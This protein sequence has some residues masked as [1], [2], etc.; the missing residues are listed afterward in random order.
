MTLL[1]ESQRRSQP[2]QDTRAG[3]KSSLQQ[4]SQ[5]AGRLASIDFLRG[6]VMIVMAL[7][8]TRD[9]FAAGGFNPRDV[10]DPALFLTRWITH[11]CAPAF[12]FLAGIS[13]C[14][15][16]SQGRTAGEVS[17]YLLTRGLWLVLIE[18]TVVRLGW[19]FSFDLGN[20]VM[21]VIFAIGASMIA[22]AALVHLPRWAIAV[23]GLG[24]ILGHNMLDGFKA[25]TFGAA[26]PLWHLLHQ[27]GMLDL[28]AGIKL[29]AL[30]PLIPW[31]GVMA[32][33]YAL[34]P[35]FALPRPL[36]RRWLGG[37]GIATIA[38]FILLRAGNLYGDPAPWTAHES[39]LATALSFVN[40]EKYPPSL[41]YLS[42]TLGPALLCLAA[43]DGVRGRA[44]DVIMTFGRVP[45]F[46]YVAHLFL[47]HALAVLFAAVTLGQVGW[48]FGG[49]PAGKPAGYGLGL[50]GIYAVWLA[51]IAILYPLCLWFSA[52]KR[53]RREWWW[54][55]L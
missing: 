51:V 22:L 18:F 20:F 55:Y 7:D 8:H 13:A 52:V 37:L 27:P 34:G 10:A 30:Y 25:E 6:L 2:R 21:Q 15:Y 29:F 43:F 48:L 5:A 4:Q 33:G 23:V 39:L 11:F 1:F 32:A 53:R 46:Y 19:M 26:A 17:R 28:G 40:C 24:M 47:I 41:L 44:A 35:V 3:G 31:I 54:T 38:G 16:G 42:M 12:I 49:M 36:R 9:F 14:L 50:P 45:F